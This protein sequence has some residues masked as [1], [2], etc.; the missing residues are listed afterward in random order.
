MSVAALPLRLVLLGLRRRQRLISLQDAARGVP[1]GVEHLGAV[2]RGLQCA[3]EL[4]ARGLDRPQSLQRAG[5]PQ[6]PKV[7]EFVRLKIPVSACPCQGAIRLRS[8]LVGVQDFEV[9]CFVAGVAADQPVGVAGESE[10]RHG[11]LD[12]RR[13]VAL[14]DVGTL[15]QRRPLDLV[16]T[17]PHIDGQLPGCH[18][19]QLD[20]AVH[21]DGA[22]DGALRYRLLG[23]LRDQGLDGRRL[24]GDDFGAGVVVTHQPSP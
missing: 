21:V 14:L 24:L 19:Q 12:E 15:H 22:K 4:H 16:R 3:G 13:E 20:G 2:L 11:P 10:G 18:R 1:R 9:A 5:H 17:T 7:L 8:A 6:Q 23:T